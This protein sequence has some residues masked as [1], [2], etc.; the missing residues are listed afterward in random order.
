MALEKWII[1]PGQ[2]RVIDIE[3]ARSL[4]VGLVGGGVTVI[5]HD[6]PGLRIE[7]SE[8]SGRDL[9]VEIDG[10]KVEIDHP[11]L[12]WDNFLDVFKGFRGNMRAVVSVL[13][14][15]ETALKLGVVSADALIAGFVGDAKLSTVNGDVAV[16]R[17]VGDLELN[18]VTGE[19]S[20]GSHEGRIGA[21]SVSGDIAAT[22]TVTRFFSDTVSG[23][24]IL[25]LEGVPSRID[26]NTI[27]GDLTVRLDAHASAR[28]R[29][30]TVSGTIFIDDTSIRGTLGKGYERVVGDL[31]GTWT[32]FG[33]N[34]VSGNVSVMRRQPGEQSDASGETDADAGDPTGA[35]PDAE[36]AATA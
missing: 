25:D 15:R 4:K 8:V 10:D 35:A 7:V 16:D 32:D 5:A 31:A 20:V 12:R 22:G 19:I 27:S 30:N 26:A 33:A 23:D 21:H 24:V 28:F 17:H 13:A 11:Q 18:S 3:L 34:S 1:S 2:S 14:P 29:V 6:E 9:R 36:T